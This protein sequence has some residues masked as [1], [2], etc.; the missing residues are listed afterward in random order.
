[1]SNDRRAPQT[2]PERI[3]SLVPSLTETCFDV[4]LGER[5]VGVTDWCVHPAD[6]VAALPKVGGTK[7]ADVAAIEALKPDLVIANHEENTRRVV[8]ELEQRGLRVW[9][10]YPRTLEEGTRVLHELVALSP[11]R[12]LARAVAFAAERALGFLDEPDTTSSRPRVFCP[13]WRDPWMAVGR[14]TYASD[15]IERCGGENVFADRG[16][17]RYPIVTLEDVVA[18]A[19][20]VVLLP[21]EP[22]SFGAVDASEI[23]ELEIPAAESARVHLIDG[24]WVSWY[25]S[26][27]AKAVGALRP[28][29]GPPR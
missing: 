5:V 27:I 18:A 10:T 22:Y 15:L 1:M 24:T 6:G 12:D 26:R 4:G 3:V 21:D 9:L 13:I 25:G 14:D 8:E 28:L 17:R 16:D 7:D 29:L 20:D 23:R 2:T 19:P 11:D